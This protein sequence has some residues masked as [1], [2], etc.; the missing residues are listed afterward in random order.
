M[1]HAMHRAAQEGRAKAR[2]RL[3]AA[4]AS[5]NASINTGQ[6][7]LSQ[8]HDAKAAALVALKGSITSSQKRITKQADLFR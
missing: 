5:I 3:Q 7:L 6:A 4:Q 2:Q 8:E 1:T